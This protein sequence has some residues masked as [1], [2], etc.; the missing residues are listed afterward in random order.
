MRR[1]PRQWARAYIQA[2]EGIPPSDL[3]TLALALAQ[4]LKE[5]GDLSRTSEIVRALSGVW[6]EQYGAA[7]VDIISAHPLSEKAREAIASAIPTASLH[8]TV[9]PA[10]IGGAVV[11]VDDRRMD[12][13]VS[14]ALRSVRDSLVSDS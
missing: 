3:P 1:T 6:K 5:R 12:G 13:S 8:E 10:L 4:L 7:D 9:D 14:G 2:A 11:R